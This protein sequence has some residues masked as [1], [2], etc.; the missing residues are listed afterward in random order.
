MRTIHGSYTAS[1]VGVMDV[2]NEISLVFIQESQVWSI[3]LINKQMLIIYKVV[4]LFDYFNVTNAPA[5][6]DRQKFAVTPPVVKPK[7]PK[8]R[9][10]S[11]KSACVRTGEVH[12]SSKIRLLPI[13]SCRTHDHSHW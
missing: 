13:L 1:S 2:V 10:K 4:A 8:R 7:A 3:G 11:T 12:S 6:L 5:Y 9:S